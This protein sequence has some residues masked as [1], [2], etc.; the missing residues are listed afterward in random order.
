MASAGLNYRCHISKEQI[1]ELLED[2]FGHKR[3]THEYKE[4]LTDLKNGDTVDIPIEW[5]GYVPE[6][7]IPI[8]RNSIQITSHRTSE[9][10]VF[11]KEFHPTMRS[12]LEREKIE[13]SLELG[14]SLEKALRGEE[15][16]NY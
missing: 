1:S 10:V 13:Y 7:R 4:Y 2:V 8:S 3:N 12:F 16:I 9:E 6:V 5:L 11:A 14:P 15:P